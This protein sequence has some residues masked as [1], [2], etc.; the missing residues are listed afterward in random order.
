VTA[1]DGMRREKRVETSA[2]ADRFGLLA[3]SV[4]ARGVPFDLV[5]L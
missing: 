2:P 4:M 1:P 3:F 5:K